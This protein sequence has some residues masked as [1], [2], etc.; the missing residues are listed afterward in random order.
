MKR[1]LTLVLLTIGLASVQ[2]APFTVGNVVVLQ[3]GTAGT[4]AAGALIEYTPS[5]TLVQTIS[6]PNNGTTPDA[7][8]IVFGQNSAFNHSLSLSADG[9][10]VV[11]PGYAN[12]L[13]SGVIDTV[14][15]A[16]GGANRVVGTVKYDGTYTRPFSSASVLSG[17]AFRTATSDGFGNFWGMGGSGGTWYLNTGTSLQS[18]TGRY[19]S[20]VDGNLCYTLG[21]GVLQ[22]PGAPQSA[23][24]GTQIMTMN[25]TSPSA[26]S[27]AVSTNLGI[28]YVGDVRTTGNGVERFDWNGS[29]WV[30]TYNL[31]LPSPDRPQHVA[32]DFSGASPVIF[33]V[34]NSFNKLYVITDT[35][36]GSTAAQIAT[37]ASGV[38]RGV[39]LAPTQPAAPVFTTQPTGDTKNYGETMVFGPVGATGANPNG[40]TWKHGTTTLSDGGTI[41]G[42]TT[43]T[44]T[45]SGLTAGDAGSYY[46][47]AANNGGTT[48]SDPAVLTLQ[49]S[50]INPQLVSITNAAGTTANFTAGVSGCQGPIASYSWTRDGNPVSDG[51]YWTG[52]VISGA[53]TAS[54]TISGVQDGDA[55]LYTVTLIDN[56]SQPSSSAATLT[57]VDP[58]SITLQPVSITKA[59]GTTA[60]FSVEATGGSLHY[61]WFKNAA[62]LTD[63]L[64]GSG[65]TIG[66]ATTASLSIANVQDADAGTYSVTVTNLAGSQ[67]SDPATLTVVHAPAVAAL[68]STNLWVGSNVVWQVV[69]TGTPPLNYVWRRNGEVLFDDAH[70]AGASTDT[71]MLT[72]V[73]LADAN[74]YSITVDNDY[75]QASSSAQLRIIIA[76]P[77]PS[78]IPGLVIL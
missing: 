63:G 38:F 34:N 44:L 14:S 25:G 77:Q 24:S 69:A 37:P 20:L 42:S 29:A 40:W 70:I 50:C 23:S 59:A 57:V 33:A 28:A 48:S 21:A 5:G 45:I 52:S 60:N 67:P 6:L 11:I 61:N 51:T 46:A 64:T 4:G 78:G 16:S 26:T 74:T 8:S 15:V 58:P 17:V 10:L 31:A 47:I 68:A 3:S 49:G 76:G 73:Q 22:F 27:F 71:L 30:F 1:L 56:N 13:V 9:A 41:S 35:G 53:T 72:D 75:G 2:A 55:G 32:V 66:G 62:P 36:S 19:V 54:L 18:S 7:T 39:T 43:T 65:A 12:M